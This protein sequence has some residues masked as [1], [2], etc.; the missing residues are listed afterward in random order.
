[1]GALALLGRVPRGVPAPGA[2][3]FTVAAGA[4]D[5]VANVCF[6]LATR[7]GLLTV[8]SVLT[9]LYPVGTVLLARIVLKERFATIQ[10]I[11]VAIAIPAA[12]LMAT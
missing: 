2:R 10:R 8:V 1:M 6:L 7:E 12:I 9:A 4:L 3:S 11:G 5:A